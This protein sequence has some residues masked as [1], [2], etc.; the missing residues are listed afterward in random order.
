MRA[1]GLLKPRRHTR[2]AEL[3]AGGEVEHA[4]R[5]G[6][7]AALQ[8]GLRPGLPA[9][10]ERAGA[11]GVTTSLDPSWDPANTWDGGLRAL[12][13]RCDV[14]LPNQAEAQLIAGGEPEAAARSLGAGAGV[15]AMKLGEAGALAVRGE[16]VVSVEAPTVQVVDTTGAGDSFDAGFLA[17]FLGGWDLRRSLELVE[18][19]EE[20]AAEELRA[21]AYALGR[22]LGREKLSAQQQREQSPEHFLAHLT[23]QFGSS[24]YPRVRGGAGRTAAGRPGSP[25]HQETTPPRAFLAP[26]VCLLSLSA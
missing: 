20:L 18:E 17:G 12:L 1:I 26:V 2:G 22:L 11:A 21:A 24:V 5:Q 7:E 23:P 16:E 25:T 4:V 14:F 19:G 10:F 13:R 6:E 15:V 9:L 3:G 8:G